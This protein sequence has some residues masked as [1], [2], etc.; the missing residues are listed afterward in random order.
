MYIL[1][2]LKS[3]SSVTQFI[4]RRDLKWLLTPAIWSVPI[5]LNDTA[6][7]T[8]TVYVQ[9]GVK[10]H[11]QCESLEV[12]TGHNLKETNFRLLLVPLMNIVS[13]YIIQ[14]KEQLTSHSIHTAARF[15]MAAYTCYV[16]GTITLGWHSCVD[17]NDICSSRREEAFA[18][19][20]TRGPYRTQFKR[21]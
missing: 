21:N 4:R 20:V 18:T 15:K 6:A 3:N 9:V 2:K 14:I 19:R 5:H 8:R 7:S 13:I 11:S 12:L 10:K 1:Y 17:W 16:V